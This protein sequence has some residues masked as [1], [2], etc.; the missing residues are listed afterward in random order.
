M[1]KWPG[2]G[3]QVLPACGQQSRKNNSLACGNF[4]QNGDT[5]DIAYITRGVPWTTRILKK[6]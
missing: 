3:N 5:I 2:S 4:R 1:N 6:A